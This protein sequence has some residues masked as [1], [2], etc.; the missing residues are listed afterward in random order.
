MPVPISRVL[1]R[2]AS[3]DQSSL[4]IKKQQV[5]GAQCIGP[6]NVSKQSPSGRWPYRAIWLL[7][8]SLMRISL[9]TA[10]FSLAID[11]FIATAH[12][13]RIKMKGR[14]KGYPVAVGKTESPNQENRSHRCERTGRIWGNAFGHRRDA[15]SSGS[16]AQRLKEI[17]EDK[18]KE[19][20]CYCK[21]FTCALRSALALEGNGWKNV[22]VMEGGIMAWPYPRENKYGHVCK[23]EFAG[24]ARR[25]SL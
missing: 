22:K 1:C 18:N 21:I 2:E 16:I 10:I 8:I 19:I 20:T 23:L 4:P 13:S 24:R 3:G 14:L 12:I 6:G 7:R 11:H 15:D 9:S 25:D 17:P 5:L